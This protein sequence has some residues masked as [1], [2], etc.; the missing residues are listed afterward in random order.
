MRVSQPTNRPPNWTC[1]TESGPFRVMPVK[2]ASRT[3][4]TSQTMWYNPR[5][6]CMKAE[7][8]GEDRRHK[9]RVRQETLRCS[10]GKVLDLSAT[11]L[12]VEL[13]QK[14][15]KQLRD[16]PFDIEIRGICGGVT[17]K[18]EVAWL[19]RKGLRKAEA[20]VRFLELTPEHTMK[21]TELSVENRLLRHLHD[22][23][24]AA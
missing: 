4:D 16:K 15:P 13:T 3:T 2:L 23:D 11:G 10:L 24:L 5:N 20:G 14:L 17:L 12:R 6:D 8:P 21:L 1:E 7:E 22:G 18:A 19:K 9:G